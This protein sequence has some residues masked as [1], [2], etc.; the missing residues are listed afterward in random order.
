MED[1][2]LPQT[3]EKL[4]AA[5]K[6]MSSYFEEPSVKHAPEGCSDYRNGLL[7]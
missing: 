4:P 2:L 1:H 7:G 3:Q 5:A 6:L